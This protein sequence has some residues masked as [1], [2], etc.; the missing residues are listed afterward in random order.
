MRFLDGPD[1]N[2]IYDDKDYWLV[3]D[4]EGSEVGSGEQDG[5]KDGLLLEEKTSVQ[6]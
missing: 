4:E 6:A 2:Q 1:S 3:P 5:V